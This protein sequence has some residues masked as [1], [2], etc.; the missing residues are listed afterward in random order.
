MPVMESMD[1]DA[2]VYCDTAPLCPACRTGSP[3][4]NEVLCERCLEPLDVEL[5]AQ[6]W[7][8][9][10]PPRLA[11][12]EVWYLRATPWGFE[13]VYDVPTVSPVRA[14]GLLLAKRACP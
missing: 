12:G 11:D 13:R 5:R 8:E 10:E 3:A 6:R 9:P 14:I 2:R 7:P 4:F 1:P